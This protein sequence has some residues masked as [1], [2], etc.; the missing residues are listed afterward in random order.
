[1]N[2]NTIKAGDIVDLETQ[3]VFRDN[4]FLGFTTVDTQY[5]EDPV[6]KT[7]K[8]AKEAYGVRTNAE[9]EEV[10]E[11]LGYGHSIYAIFETPDTRPGRGGT[12]TWGAYLFKGRWCAGSGA[13]VIRFV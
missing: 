7:L 13:D 10:G 9:L 6:F 2:F 12:Y 1:M 8:E 11:D 3:S 5:S 4:K